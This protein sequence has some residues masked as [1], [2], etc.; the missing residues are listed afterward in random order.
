MAATIVI[1]ITDNNADGV[2]SLGY[3][4]QY[5]FNGGTEWLYN[6]TFLTSPIVLENMAEG[7][8]Y[9]ISVTRQCC[10]GSTATPSIFVVSAEGLPE[11]TGLTPSQ[12]GA[13]VQLNWD[14]YADA[15]SYEIQRAD[16]IGF[17]TNVHN[18]TS[19]T[20]NYTD[21]ASPAM[22]LYYRVRAIVNGVASAWANTSITVT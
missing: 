8:E 19:P 1:P 21:T 16:D 2:C 17:T 20:S 5:R 15:D 14:D 10:D 4:V 3:I 12:L 13:D 22:L 7:Q 18:Y 6:D 9:E 11:P